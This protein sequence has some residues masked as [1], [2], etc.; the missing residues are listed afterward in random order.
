M[1]LE[2]SKNSGTLGLIGRV[3]KIP[4]TGQSKAGKETNKTRKIKPEPFQ[5]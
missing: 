5:G 4:G 3:A 1:L 2:V